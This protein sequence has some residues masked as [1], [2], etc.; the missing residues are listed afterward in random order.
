MTVQRHNP[1]QLGRPSGFS[2][3]VTARGATL[4]MLAGQTA[5]G[6]DGRI[7]GGGIVTQFERALWRLLE[8]LHAVGGSPEHLARVTVYATDVAAYREAATEIGV[9]WRRLAGSHY[10]AMALVGVTRLWEE[11]ALVELDGVAVLP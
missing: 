7:V 1:E 10:P 2:H 4:V 8:A 3:V 5:L 6:D 11:S 9:V